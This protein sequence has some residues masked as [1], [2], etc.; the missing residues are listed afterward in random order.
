MNKLYG[1]WKCQNSGFNNVLEL[2]KILTLGEDGGWENGAFDFLIH[3]LAASCKF[4]SSLCICNYKC[5][6]FD[7]SYLLCQ[8]SILSPVCPGSNLCI[9]NSL[10]GCGKS[11][12]DQA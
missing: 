3:F 1:L 2:Y 6:N 12:K 10:L 7:I 11:I 5:Y 9:G 8:V 4:I